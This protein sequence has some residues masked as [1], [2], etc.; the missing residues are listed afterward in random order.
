MK[1]ITYQK[2]ADTFVLKELA[3]PKPET[4]LDVV[5]KVSAIG[6]NP[7]DAKVNFWADMVEDMDDNFVGGLDV[8]G[9]IVEVGEAVTEWKVGDEVLYHGNM[10]RHCGGFAEYALQD[11]RTLVAKPCVSHEVAAAT[12]CAAWTA[13]RALHDK[14]RIS[15]RKSLFIAGG[16]GGVGSFAIQLAKLAGVKTIITSSSELKHNYVKSLGATH[17]I[18]YRKQDVATE[19]MKITQGQGVECS[20]D[21]VGGENA[22]L[23]ARVLAFEGEMV[24]LVD[25]VNPTLYQDAFMKGLSFHQLSLG[26]GHVHGLQGRDSIIRSGKVVSEMLERGELVVPELKII[27]LEEIGQALRDMR[28]QRTMGKIVAKIRS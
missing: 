22:V 25:T 13:Y 17:A 11:S 8:S 15:E 21:C 9:K 16:A 23:S 12:P 7:V 24:E 5:I 1:A 4:E 14:L 6:L 28:S 19:I 3:R 18:D 27:D 10:R 20:L 2:S 26:S